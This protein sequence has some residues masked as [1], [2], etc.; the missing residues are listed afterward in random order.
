MYQHIDY[1]CYNYFMKKPIKRTPWGK[2]Q[3]IESVTP[4]MVV[5]TTA[6]HGGVKIEKKQNRLI[7]SKYRNESGWYEEDCACAIPI[8]FLFDLIQAERTG[9]DW[10]KPNKEKA[11]ADIQRWF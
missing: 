4:W 5:V 9:A 10:F 3:T 6:R 8:Y 7:P 2:P 11:F 1:N